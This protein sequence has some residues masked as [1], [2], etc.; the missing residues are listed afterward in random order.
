MT[1]P[2]RLT[3][4]STG[5]WLRPAYG[6]R[7]GRHWLDVA[8]Y[9][10]TAGETADYPV[11]EA[12]RYRNYVIEAFNDDKPYDQF[13]REQVAGDILA[14]EGPP[15]KFAERD[16]RHRLHRLSRRFGFDSINYQHLDIRGHARHARPGRCSACR[17]AAPAATITST[18]RSRRPTTT[19]LYGIFASTRYAFPGD[20]QTKRPRDFVPLVP[21]ASS[22]R[23][24]SS[25]RSSLPPRRRDAEARALEKNAVA[26]QS[27]AA[28][29]TP[30]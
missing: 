28:P 26:G 1:R 13:L 9:A 10:D 29:T 25:T 16:R 17:S 7:W 30:S 20:E 12:W 24:S 27:A 14:R 8:R 22:R 4:W 2:T 6:E 15:E 11:R 19:R 23:S 21:P 18:T 5:C 3:R